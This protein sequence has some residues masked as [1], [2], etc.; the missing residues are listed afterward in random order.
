MTQ[1]QRSELEEEL[2]IQLVKKIKYLGIW[3]TAKATTIKEDNYTK[4]LKEIKKDLEIWNR[5]QL[6]LMGR[7]S[8]IKMN[9]LP[10]VLYLYQVVPL[11]PGRDFFKNLNKIT[12]TYIWQGKKARIKIKALQDTRDRGGLAVPD[13]E[14][15]YKAAGLTWIKEWMRLDDKRMLYLEG[16]DL[17]RGW[18]AFLWDGPDKQ[19]MYFQRHIIRASLFKIW[20]GIKKTYYT[21]IPKWWSPMEALIFPNTLEIG[22]I[23]RYQDLLN[24]E[25]E[26]TPRHQLQNGDTNIDWWHYTQIYSRYKADKI[27]YGIAK[28]LNELD[29]ILLGADQKMI[30]KTYNYLLRDKLIEETVKH[31]MT[32]WARD[33]GHNIQLAD[34]EKL[35]KQNI[36]MTRATSYKE[37][38]IKMF[39]RWHLPPARLAKIHPNTS[40]LC[41]KCKSK[42][43]TYY[44][45]WWKCRKAQ[46]YWQDIKNIIEEI[47]NIQIENSPEFFLFGMITAQHLKETKYLIIHILTA[48]RLLFAQNW[49]S[50]QLPSKDKIVAKI[51][52]CAEMDR[53][54]LELQEKEES[55]YYLVWHQWYQWL[56]RKI[57]KNVED[58][59]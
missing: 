32:M 45:T 12:M 35:W 52:E 33:I 23:M 20:Q 58:R 46:H 42:K 15:Y 25:G 55:E 51:T 48:A 8:S 4:L 41:W 27:K 30:T 14:L 7:I 37:N 11:H 19:H 17:I 38:L 5:L 49:K 2:G 31:N 40:A 21:K 1:T 24:H 53:L 3:L 50:D 10:R 54:T 28:D 39:Y 36:K 29:R 43:G 44:H 13:W 47:T 22:K 16:F 57:S 18:H 34:W 26:L 9:I 59:N 6:S 56:E